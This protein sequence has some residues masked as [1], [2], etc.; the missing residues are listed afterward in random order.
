MIK[1]LTEHDFRRGFE[2][3]RPDNF[4]YDGLRVLFEYFERLEDDCGTTIE[5][6]VI[7]ICCDFSEMTLDE[8]IDNYSIEMPN[9]TPFGDDDGEADELDDDEREEVVLEYLTDHGHGSAGVT[10]DKTVV[11]QV[12]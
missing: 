7:A 5:Y 3:L 9:S 11:F 2:Q 10:S 4:S 1:T 8:I 6:D 12:F